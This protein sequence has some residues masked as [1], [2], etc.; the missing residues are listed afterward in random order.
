[1]SH[2]AAVIEHM[3]W[4]KSGDAPQPQRAAEGIAALCG[5]IVQKEVKRLKAEGKIA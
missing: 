1:M 2:R 4:A 3:G 5:I